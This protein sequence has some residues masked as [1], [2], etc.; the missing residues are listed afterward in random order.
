MDQELFEIRYRDIDPDSGELTK[1]QIICTCYSKLTTEWVYSA[2]VR[3]M[4]LDYDEPN[5]EIYIKSTI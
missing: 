2:I 3:D 5:R 4:S 1:D